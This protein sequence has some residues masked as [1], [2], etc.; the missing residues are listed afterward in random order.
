MES[1]GERCEKL[2]V[3]LHRKRDSKRQIGEKLCR[4]PIACY[5]TKF[6][7]VA[8]VK[9]VMQLLTDI[10]GLSVLTDGQLRGAA[11]RIVSMCC[12]HVCQHMSCREV[13]DFLLE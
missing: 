12:T 11:G 1:V 8:N 13:V 5:R 9:R 3:S 4:I 7:C 10:D 6:A 2:F